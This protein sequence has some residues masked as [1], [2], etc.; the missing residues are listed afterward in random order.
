M[1]R[2]ATQALLLTVSLLL[3]PAFASAAD[4]DG[5]AEIHGP[6]LDSEI[7]IRTTERLAGAID[8]V[9]WRGQEFIDSADHGRQL[10][11]ASNFDVDG[12]FIP[13]TFNPTEAGSVADGAGPTSTSQLLHL[14]AG[15]NRLQTTSQMAFW[16]PPDGKSQGNPARNTTALSNHL[17]TKRVTI[18]YRDLP[19][20]IQYDVTFG[21]PINESHSYAQFEVVTGYMPEKFT[22]FLGYDAKTD[23]FIELDRGPGEQKLPIVLATADGKFAMGCFTPDRFGPGWSG[24]GY[25]RFEFKWAHVTKWNCV[26]RLRNKEGVPPGDFSFRTFVVMGNLPLVREG[27]RE[28]TTEFAAE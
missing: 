3:L 22:K 4:P 11:S 18:G 7:V 26:F 27:L 23:S 17:L 24:P 13:E 8:S 1:K 2:F 6:L 19:Q 9:T 10:Q 12:Q 28:L 25:G 15:K 14:L 16:L 21:L 20:V 5:A